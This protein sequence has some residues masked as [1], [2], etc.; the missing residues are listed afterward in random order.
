[1][2]NK[3]LAGAT[4]L[5]VVAGALWYIKGVKPAG[6]EPGAVQLSYNLCLGAEFHSHIVD[7]DTLTFTNYRSNYWLDSSRQYFGKAIVTGTKDTLLVSVINGMDFRTAS[8]LLLKASGE[9]FDKKREQYGPIE[10]FGI[11]SRHSDSSFWVRSLVFDKQLGASI[12]IDQ[13]AAD[14][15]S[16]Q[17]IF[18]Q[19]NLAKTIK[20]CI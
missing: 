7:L 6:A 15:A 8:E 9:V 11:Y 20:R 19:S 10:A 4:I 5:L 16:A 17:R 12:L 14:K 1:M 18:I 2:R 13:H 3:I